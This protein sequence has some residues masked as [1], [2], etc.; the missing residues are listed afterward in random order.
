MEKSKE[1]AVIQFCKHR[2]HGNLVSIHEGIVKPHRL[3]VNDDEFHFG[4][5]HT[6]GLDGSLDGGLPMKT[7]RYRVLALS[8]WEKTVQIPI[9]SKIGRILTQNVGFTLRRLSA[10]YRSLAGGLGPVM[11]SPV[12]KS[13]HLFMPLRIGC[14]LVSVKEFEARL[15]AGKACDL[16]SLFWPAEYLDR[17][18]ATLAGIF[19]AKE[20][21]CKA[22]SLPPG[23]WLDICVE[24]KSSGE[25]VIVLM[26]YYANIETI[27]VSITHAGD[28]ALAFVVA[29]TP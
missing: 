23:R 15:L 14:D 1:R 13:V 7:V 5:E 27:S 2:I 10:D 16:E 11:M 24:H 3:C 22:L 26:N 4:V 29:Q 6:L 12:W 17:S 18:V 8:G 25:P 28:Y 19:A 20:A 21:V 9:E